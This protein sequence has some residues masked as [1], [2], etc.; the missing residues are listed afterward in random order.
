M[1][2]DVDSN[3]ISPV[4][5]QVNVVIGHFRT[6]SIELQYLFDRVRRIIGFDWLQQQQLPGSAVL[7]HELQADGRN[8]YQVNALKPTCKRGDKADHN[9][10]LAAPLHCFLAQTT[11]S[12]TMRLH[13]ISSL[14]LLAKGIDSTAVLRFG[15]SQITV[16]RLDP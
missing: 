3:F 14:L 8:G 16:E 4:L 10:F 6:S 5:Y 12:L 2:D 13:T 7:L 15:C 11:S 9:I 1:N